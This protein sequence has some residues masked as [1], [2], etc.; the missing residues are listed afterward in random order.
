MSRGE[1]LT[2][3]KRAAGLVVVVAAVVA[4]WLTLR[5]AP[6]TPPRETPPATPTSRH[7]RLPEYPDTTLEARLRAIVSGTQATARRLSR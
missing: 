7:D 2:V 3:V 5:P 6:R 1:R 4:A